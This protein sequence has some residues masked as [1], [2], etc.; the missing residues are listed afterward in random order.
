MATFP[1]KYF[2]YSTEYPESG[3]RITLGESYQF[4]VMPEA[5]DQ[6][7]FKLKLKA[8]CYFVDQ[9]DVI[10]LVFEP[11]RN[12]AVLEAFYNTHKRAKAFD[13][14]HPVYGTVRCKFNRPLQIPEGVAGGN[15]HL[16]DLDVELIEIP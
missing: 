6:R 12:M 15:G 8:M 3:Q 13:F 7:I 1:A 10:S 9:N 2:T 4:D 16:E 14:P 11:A 5:P